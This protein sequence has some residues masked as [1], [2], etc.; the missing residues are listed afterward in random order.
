MRDFINRFTSA[1]TLREGAVGLLLIVGL[2]SFV[3]IFLWLNR[4]SVGKK[5]Y[6][7]TV[8]FANA[9]GMQKGSIVRYRGVTVGTIRKI[10]TGSNSVDVEIEISNPNLLIPTN[11]TIEANQ[12]GLVSQ[13]IIDITP[14]GNV[15]LAQD[16]P[17]P[18]DQDCNAKLIICNG[19]RLRGVIGISVDELVRQSASF[20]AQYSNDQFYKNVNKALESSAL[21][22][23]NIANLTKDLQSLT[24]T[25]QGQVGV[26]SS[27]A[28]TI[29]KS[30]N[31]LTAT[32]QK[33]AAQLATTAKDFSGTA[34][35]ASQLLNNLDNLL[36]ANRTSLVTSLN[37]MTE[38][39]N[40]LRVTVNSLSPAVNRLTQGE[41]LNN[42][43]L[44]S[45]NA[46]EASANLKDASKT[47]NDPK[48]IVLL[49]QTLDAARVTFENTQKIT[50]DLDELTG[51]PQFRQNLLRL[52]NGLSKLVSST[53][54]IEQ[55]TKVAVTL[56]SL[57]TSMN[58][59]ETTK[60]VTKKVVISKSMNPSTEKQDLVIDTSTKSLNKNVETTEILPN[61]TITNYPSPAQEKLLKQLREYRDKKE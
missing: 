48:N 20:A 16:I 43:E 21:A 57:K 45:A 46:A 44:L 42:L 22:A 54:D 25:A 36:T 18:L 9:G 8:E 11:S 50:S 33:T 41:I 19:S 14:Q 56:D 55:Q 24:K 1:R 49:Q 17:G 3:G 39:S 7:A 6:Y 60:Q 47:L 15:T 53:Q 29:Q 40:Q 37:N 10:N 4:I 61:P 12:S 58:Q 13:N 51:D 32:S 52:V 26:F 27:T 38:V 31:Q 30:T 34:K 59:P 5:S 28:L 2:G 35:Q 23:T